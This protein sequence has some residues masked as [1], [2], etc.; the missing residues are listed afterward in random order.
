MPKGISFRMFDLVI[1]FRG[2]VS[3]VNATYPI[4]DSYYSPRADLSQMLCVFQ[5]SIMGLKNKRDESFCFLHVGFV[6]L[7]KFHDA[8]AFIRSGG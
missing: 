5:S 2:R 6:F 3:S 7:P 4:N 8:L 1:R